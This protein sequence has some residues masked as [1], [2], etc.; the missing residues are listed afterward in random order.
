MRRPFGRPDRPGTIPPEILAGPSAR[1]PF[2]ALREAPWVTPPPGAI[3]FL[4]QE[5][6]TVTGA[7]GADTTQILAQLNTPDHYRGVI[8]ELAYQVNDVVVSSNIQFALRFS[9][10]KIPGATL[11]IFPKSASTDLIEF[12][13][14]TTMFRLPM[15]ALIDVLVTV[16]AGDI[17][18]YLVG[19][20][21]KGWW[22]PEEM[23]T[24]FEAGHA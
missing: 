13:P 16:R 6:A 5:R 3:N 18:T 12:D 10:G 17:G 15:N 14:P 9:Q 8:R 21:Y 23:D 4:G 20:V 1:A 22:Y 11:D 24:A 7:A 19:A 2:P